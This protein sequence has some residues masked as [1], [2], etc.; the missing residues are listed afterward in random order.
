MKKLVFLIIV[1]VNWTLLFS[2]TVIPGGDVSGNWLIAGSPYLIEGEINIP[3][4]STLTIE[5][6]VEVIFQGHY[7]LWV[8]GYLEAIGT[9]NDSISFTAVDTIDGWAGIR[10]SHAPDSSH[11]SFCIIQYGRAIGNELYYWGGGIGCLDS[12]PIISNCIIRQNYAYYDGGGIACSNSNPIIS[13]CIISGNV[14]GNAGSGGGIFCVYYSSPVIENCVISGNA[15]GIGGGGIFCYDIS[16]PSMTNVTISENTTNGNGGGIYCYNSNPSLLNCILWNDS[17][18]EI[19]VSSGSVTATYSDIQGSWAGQGNIDADPL[20]AN[21]ENGDFHLTENSPCIDAGD[22]NFPFDPDGTIAD[23]GAFYYDQSVGVQDENIQ[24][25]MLSHQLT[26]YPN[27]FNP[28]TIIEFSIQNNSNIELSVY[29]VKGQKVKLLVSNQLSAG[30]H[31][32][33]WNGDD[34]SG[35]FVSSGVYYYKLNV[36]GRI[37]AVKK[38]LMIK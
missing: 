6:G 14:T 4:D 8:Y 9:E 26:N 24:F 15:A 30:Q 1:I 32:F 25:S 10:F 12:N 28:S 19:Y 11:L 21:P 29:N 17:P 33:I 22:P 36:N 7:A 37:E 38:C 20:F 2:Q 5:P 23:M 18:E 34:E 31:S 16:S 3:V 27:P 13:N 35:K